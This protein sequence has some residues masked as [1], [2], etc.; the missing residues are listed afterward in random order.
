MNTHIHT[1]TGRP[2]KVLERRSDE[3][4]IDFGQG[5]SSPF[6]WVPN[7]DLKMR[8]IATAT[9]T[10]PVRSLVKSPEE[11][12]DD[13]AFHYGVSFVD[14]LGGKVTHGGVRR[15]DLLRLVNAVLAAD[16][17]SSSQ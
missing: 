3:T 13:W 15:G 16:K 4:F 1:P 7:S 10:T 17:R 9:P 12:L 8:D 11:L 5:V 6:A 2:C 14:R